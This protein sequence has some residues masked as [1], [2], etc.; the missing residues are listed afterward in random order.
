P[1]LNAVS[2]AKDGTFVLAVAPDPGKE[3][4]FTVRIDGGGVT[5]I[6]LGGVWDATETEDLGDHSLL[7]GGKLSG[8]VT[9]AAGKPVAE[10]EV[11]LATQPDRVEQA[12]LEAAPRFTKTAADGTFHFDDAGA[13]GNELSVEKAGLLAAQLR[14]VK[15]GALAKPIVLGS[16]VPVTGV[17]R[18]SDGSS[19]AVGALVRIE[20]GITTRWVET[21]ESGAFTVANARA[22]IA[23]VVADAGEG[24]YLALP[25]TTLPLP[26][27]KTLTLVLRPPATLAGR[28]LDAK[29]SRPVPRA[30]IEVRAA[31]MVRSARSGPDGAYAFRALPPATWQVRADE[32]R[33][34][35][36]THRNVAVRAGEAKKLEIPL[37]L[38]ATLSGQVVDEEGKPIGGAAGVLAQT[39]TPPLARIA[40]RM[41]GAEPPAFR[42][43]PDGTFKAGRL[44]PGETQILTVAHPAYEEATVGGVSLQPGATKA[45]IKIVLKRGA[46]VAGVVKDAEG[47]P[48]AGAEATLL[49]VRTSRGGRGGAQGFA[50]LTGTGAQERKTDSTGSDGA[51]AIRG[52]A[53]GEFVLTIK[54]AGYATAQVDPV[55]VP[56]K[57]SAPPI[58]VKLIKGATISGRVA[59]KSGVGV[60]G[61]LVSALTPSGPRFGGGGRAAADG[62][63]GPDG[64]FSIEGLTPGQRYDL[65]L[66]DPNG[67]P[68]RK[69]GVVAPASDVQITVAGD[70]RI[71]GK[72]V[73][74]ASGQPVTDFQVA[75]EPDRGGFGGMRIAI[76]GAAG[77]GAQPITVH[78]DDG[79]FALDGV[80]AG[81][82]SVVVT[83]D[84]YQ[85]AHA[86]GVVVEEGATHENVQVRL[87]KGTAL[88]GRVSDATTGAAVANATVSLAAGAGP[89]GP[90]AVLAAFTGGDVTTDASGQFEVDGVAPG[91]Q[92]LHVTH[93]DYAD[94]TQAVEV[95]NDG[96]SVEVRMI[97]GGAISGVVAADTGQPVPS[98]TVA[99]S[100][101]GSAGFG[102]LAGGGSSSVTDPAGQFSFDHLGAGRYSL[103]ASLGS[104]TS[105]PFEVV[106]LSGQ[107]QPGVTLQLQLGV[108]VQGTV[109]GLPEGMVAGTTVTASGQN[110]YFQT[111]RVGV[112]GSFEFDNVP[113][114]IVTLRGTATDPSGSTRS[115]TKQLATSA[116]Q[117]VL[118]ADLVFEQGFS[119]SGHVTQAGQ[120]VS[121]AMVFANL[122][123]GGGRQASAS[124]DDSGAYQLTGLQEGTYMVNAMSPT[125]GAS[126]RQTIALTSDQTLDIAF[127]SAK[128]AGQVVDDNGKTPLANA[129]VSI[130]AQDTS[131]TGGF[132]QRPATTDS[133]GQ[134][135][136]SGLAE[137]SYSLATSKTDFQTDTR[138]ASAADPGTDGLVIELSR[139]A[140]IA[141]KVVD[142]LAGVPLHG[143]VVRVL[144]GQG[145]SA[146]GPA[147]IALDGDGQGEI[148]ALPPGTYTVMAAASGYAPVRLDGVNVPSA[149]VTIAVT[150]GGTVLV[151]AGGKTLAPGTATGTITTTAG[152]PAMLSLFNLQGAFAISEP[153]LQ[154]RNVPP[155]S[156]VLTLPALEIAVPFAVTMGATTTVQLP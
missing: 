121:G 94:A 101:E 92:T 156:Y 86:G 5:P 76:R 18:K 41:R 78:V 104:H 122:Q 107:S 84:G 106:L 139:A 58:E 127:P 65:Q 66:F 36:W 3:K 109:S 141:I 125:I 14:A 98:A 21:G 34:V 112:D 110:S 120:P 39:T 4:L 20:G 70:G 117:P 16:G 153:N 103:T 50:N 136:F 1:T 47:Q 146:F 130:T 95:K 113:I 67:P 62:L 100:Q 55:R 35:P 68:E 77:G 118:V 11:S 155:G 2:T 96:A 53:P 12:E 27:G 129:S 7:P 15:A 88:K 60:E 43:M 28:A 133:N 105:A 144:D 59:N 90:A 148:P 6:L 140:G 22:G 26:A 119:L 74:A 30:K 69:P 143:V 51:F 147:P 93:P 9:D 138:T 8:K 48:V 57:G 44:A 73:E 124:S 71:T 19:P 114:G 29:T 91:K 13:T 149:T 82:W 97:A 46:V 37:V 134:F 56:E 45:G 79:A 108:T 145:A 17:V 25:Q 137:G 23:T 87:T 135:S 132:G 131:A 128:I 99:L 38:G 83:A 52:I 115:V 54:R 80:P 150:P 64:T 85:G 116:D 72:A 154:L 61:L 32:P 49:Q 102:L 33:Y 24:G 152:Q 126:N 42:S 111:T 142:G 63:T 75:Y 89:P 151:Q 81:T 31:G 10:A 40:R 123:G